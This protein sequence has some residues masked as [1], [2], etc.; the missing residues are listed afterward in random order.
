M[1]DKRKIERS[2]A[3]LERFYFD[4]NNAIIYFEFIS[5]LLL[6]RVAGPYVLDTRRDEEIEV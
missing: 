2:N 5:I 3:T 6:P 1:V 4:K